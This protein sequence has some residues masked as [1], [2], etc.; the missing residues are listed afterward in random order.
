MRGPGSNARRGAR[1]RGPLI[2]PSQ[3]TF[4]GFG[5]HLHPLFESRKGRRSQTS[6]F[7]PSVRVLV[8]GVM[9]SRSSIE[10]CQSF[11]IGAPMGDFY[12][13]PWS[14][15]VVLSTQRARDPQHVEEQVPPRV[16]GAS[17]GCCVEVEATSASMSRSTTTFGEWPRPVT[18]EA[19]RS[20]GNASRRRILGGRWDA[21]M[22]V[23]PRLFA[24]SQHKM[25][26]IR[27]KINKF[28]SN[29]D[30]RMNR[31]GVVEKQRGQGSGGW[32]GG[33]ERRSRGFPTD[34]RGARV[35]LAP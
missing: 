16:Y 15:C 5:S 24:S 12:R 13:R 21:V 35:A 6:S 9:R 8:A 11:A 32:R 25:K 2:V 20:T 30:L 27:F 18:K 14:C 17:G 26:K 33:C 3:Y 10:I 29:A 22:S 7:Q 4:S 19:V 31:V 23:R 28:K 1:N 34:A